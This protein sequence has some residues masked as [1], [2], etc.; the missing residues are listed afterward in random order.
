VK[1][2]PFKYVSVETVGEALDVLAEHGS[3]GKVL[4]GGQSLVP[5][6]NM[7]LARPSV[8]VDI[9]RVDELVG[10]R[11]NGRISVGAMTRQ[12]AV[13]HD[14]T[15]GEEF[16]L[17]KK[18]LQHVGHVANRSRGTFGGSVAHADPAA[19]LPAVTLALGA[20]IVIRGPE[21]ERVVEADDFFVTYYTTDVDVEELLV[22][23][24]L[25][26]RRPSAW[27]FGE[28]SR[29]EGDFA[30][31]GVAMTAETDDS[32]LVTAARLA[33]F[34][35]ADRP[36]RATEAE[37]ALVGR[38]LGEE[39]VADEVAQ[40]A[41]SGIEFA[42]DIHVSDTYRQEATVALVRR[43]VMEAVDTTQERR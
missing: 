22:E 34:G 8:L 31:A 14:A 28:V 19:E 6:M 10:M 3:E 33:L 12:V 4:A 15:I 29:R 9:G 36:L 37:Q 32:G 26:E 43:A 20:E 41:P 5:M 2:A 27:A 39:A 13:L 1:P 11:R 16:P 35:V 40:A 18:A 24:R 42:S 17:V 25:P 7:R 38:R 21:G 23:V 30:M